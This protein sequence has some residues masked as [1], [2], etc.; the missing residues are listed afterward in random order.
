MILFKRLFFAGI[1]CQV[2]LLFFLGCG[3]N[4]NDEQYDNLDRKT[5]IRLLQYLTQGKQLYLNY[6]A[7][8]HMEDGNG[9]KQLYPPL[10]ADYV[11]EDIERTVCIIKNGQQGEIT[12]NGV[13]YSLPMPHNL[14]L[15]D[16]EIAEITTYVYNKFNDTTMIVDQKEVTRILEN[17][18]MEVVY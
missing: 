6:C 12:V 16:L 7:N 18:Q 17:C 3:P 9:Y 11:M 13:K 15:S 8:C 4:E 5:R 10:K 1:L 14:H 2:G